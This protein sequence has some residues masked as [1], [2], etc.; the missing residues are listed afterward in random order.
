MSALIRFRLAHSL[1]EY[2]SDRIVVQDNGCW[3]WATKPYSTGYCMAKY[4]ETGRVLA[5]RLVYTFYRGPIPEGLHLDHLCHNA[6]LDCY[7]NNVCQHRR[8]VNPDHLEPVTPRVNAARRKS[9]GGWNARKTTCPAG[10]PYTHRDQKGRRRCRICIDR[11]RHE[12]R[13][14]ERAA[15]CPGN[16]GGDVA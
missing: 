4:E 8:C 11:Q 3:H 6:D 12:G 15:V 2:I 9:T 5:H 1:H 14:R 7:A 10:H 16:S 13:A